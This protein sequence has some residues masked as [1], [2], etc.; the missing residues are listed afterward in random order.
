MKWEKEAR[1]V[2]DAIPVHEV[3]KNMVILW[4]EKLARKKNSETV[5]MEE[6]TKTRD[7]YFDFLG[8]ETMERIQKMRDEGMSDEQL[9]PMIELNKGQVLYT[10]DLC[11]DRF[12]GCNRAMVKTTEVGKKV[13]ERMEILNLTQIIAD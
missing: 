1:E 8:Q 10:V 9:D 2:V 12:F 4:A 5:T 3:I 7:D 13:K 6:V 11:H